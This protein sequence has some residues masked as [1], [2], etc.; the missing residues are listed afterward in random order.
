[1]ET[2]AK[3]NVRII[4]DK[5]DPAVWNVYFKKVRIGSVRVRYTPA[6]TFDCYMDG[7]IIGTEAKLNAAAF[8][9]A[10]FCGYL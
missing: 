9:L 7:R 2:E 6:E 1:M 4:A 8:R 10:T 5:K 3:T